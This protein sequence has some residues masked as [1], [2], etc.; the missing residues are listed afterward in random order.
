MHRSQTSIHTSNTTDV[1]IVAQTP[2]SRVGFIP[3]VT[4]FNTLRYVHHYDS[5]GGNGN[6]NVFAHWI[7]SSLLYHA[8]KHYVNAS[9]FKHS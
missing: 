1:E 7:L 2:T 3:N 4:D 5:G 8:A 9:A 6:G